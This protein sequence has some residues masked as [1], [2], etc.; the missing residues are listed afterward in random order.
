MH[1]AVS[2]FIIKFIYSGLSCCSVPLLPLLTSWMRE[3]VAFIQKEGAK[4]S[5][6]LKGV[7]VE[8]KI[9]GCERLQARHGL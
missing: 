5:G 7:V 3:L 9:L 4:E 2:S 1:T 6:F 8:R